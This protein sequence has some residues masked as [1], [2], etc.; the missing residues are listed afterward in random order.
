MRIRTLV[1]VMFGVIAHAACS[2]EYRDLSRTAPYADKIGRTYRI[3]GD[4][5]AFGIYVRGSGSTPT[6]VDLYPR[7]HAPT[8]PEVTFTK[9]LERGRIFRIARATIFDTPID[10]TVFYT[11]ELEGEAIAAGVPVQVSLWRENGVIETGELNSKYY[12]H[13]K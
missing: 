4:V 2:A 8:G 13:I 9:P 11:V 5:S 12:E 1:I 10:D 7:A 6:I 3:V